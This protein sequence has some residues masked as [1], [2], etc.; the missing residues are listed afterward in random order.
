MFIEWNSR[1][2][3]FNNPIATVWHFANGSAHLQ[4]AKLLHPIQM[5][6][7]HLAVAL[8]EELE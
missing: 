7:P 6:T 8:E 5:G 2:H 4:K 1:T 3:G